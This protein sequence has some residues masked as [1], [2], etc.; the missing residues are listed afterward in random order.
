MN[1]LQG[2]KDEHSHGPKGVA[3]CPWCEIERLRKRP[4]VT[5]GD[6]GYIDIDWHDGPGQVLSLSIGPDGD[7]ACAGLSKK[8]GQTCSGTLTPD[9]FKAIAE[10]IQD[11]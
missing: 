7:V 9:V 3:Y 11:E 8:L 5:L 10:F 1:T 6:D 4:E 2:F